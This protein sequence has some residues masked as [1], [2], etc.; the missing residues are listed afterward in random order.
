MDFG[1][2]GLSNPGPSGYGGGYNATTAYSGPSG[3]DGGGGGGNTDP[4][5]GFVKASQ[6]RG[7][8]QGIKDYFTGGGYDYGYQRSFG[9]DLRGIGGLLLGLV[10]PALGLA[11]RGYQRFKPEL[12]L[13]KNSPTIESFLNQRKNLMEEVPLNKVNIYG[14]PEGI[15]GINRPDGTLISDTRYLDD[16]GR[17]YGPRSEPF[18]YNM[19][20]LNPNNFN[21]TTPTLDPRSIFNSDRMMF[22]DLTRS[23]EKALDKQRPGYDLGLFTIEDILNNISPLNDKKSPATIQDIKQ[24]YGVV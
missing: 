20:N 1:P 14:Q 9:K 13:L 5:G 10:N 16:D 17:L 18:N 3:G 15:V 2:G 6:P 7:G 24:Y 11:Y 23:Q 8:L 21:K 4:Y 12:N 22:A 19:P